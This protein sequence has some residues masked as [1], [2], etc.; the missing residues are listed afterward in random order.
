MNINGPIQTPMWRFPE[1]TPSGSQAL[2]DEFRPAIDTIPGLVWTSLPD[3]HVD[4]LN[5][6]W[7]EFTGLTSD[8][9]LG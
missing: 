8:E 7:I 5:Q 2:G 6:R 3:G 9:S 1:E 4:Y